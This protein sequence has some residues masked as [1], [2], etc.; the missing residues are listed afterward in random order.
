MQFNMVFLV[1]R[2]HPQNL[3]I[4]GCF[5]SAITAENHCT[6]YNDFVGPLPFNQYLGDTLVEWPG[7]YYPNR[8]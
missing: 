7:C 6:E 5:D 1:C 8:E 4:M 2:S 3:E